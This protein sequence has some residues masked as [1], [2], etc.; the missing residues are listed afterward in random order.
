MVA[1][2]ATLSGRKIMDCL[3]GV[4]HSSQFGLEMLVTLLCLL[5]L[6]PCVTSLT[7]WNAT[8]DPLPPLQPPEFG[9][10]VSTYGVTILI[11]TGELLSSVNMP[12]YEF[13]SYSQLSIMSVL[14]GQMGGIPQLQIAYNNY[15][16]PSSNFLAYYNTQQCMTGEVEGNSPFTGY[17]YYQNL[18]LQL[19]YSGTPIFFEY[20][21][22]PDY[23]L[24]VTYI[25]SPPWDNPALPRNITYSLTFQNS[26][27]Y[28]IYYEVSG[29]EY[30][31]VNENLYC[32]NSGNCSDGTVP[33]QIFSN[34][35]QLTDSYQ[36]YDA[37]AWPNDFFGAYCPFE[38]SVVTNDDN[39]VN[40]IDDDGSNND[41][42]VSSGYRSATIAF[43]ILFI[44]SFIGN[45]A[46]VYWI[47][48]KLGAKQGLLN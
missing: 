48:T 23:G 22:L 14:G 28:L 21:T 35:T 36:I 16:T 13:S 25:T 32:P 41:D 38:Q 11:S 12:G 40:S 17:D 8:T 44:F 5:F 43:V 7:L 24:C 47:R 15:S 10:Y 19:Y 9:A 45:I 37:S 20:V 34:A 27:G 3:K 18:V 4:F 2:I 42:K 6:S 26:T 1:R 46:L 30:C 33:V 29:T 39:T 31:C